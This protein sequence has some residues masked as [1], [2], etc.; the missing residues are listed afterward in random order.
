LGRLGSWQFIDQG[1]LLASIIV[2][3]TSL[4][5]KIMGKVNP[6]LVVS[7][8]QI[9]ELT[10]RKIVVASE[11]QIAERDQAPYPVLNN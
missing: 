2:F 3:D 1:L 7:R 10:K 8:S 9:R 5:R 4:W 11:G 6:D